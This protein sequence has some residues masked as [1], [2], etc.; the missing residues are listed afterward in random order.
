MVQRI[1]RAPPPRLTNPQ[2]II[3]LPF[4]CA[5]VLSPLAIWP[6]RVLP[7]FLSHQ[8]RLRL[9]LAFGNSLSRLSLWRRGWA[10]SPTSGSLV[11]SGGTGGDSGRSCA[12]A[13]L[14][15]VMPS[16]RDP[17]PD[18]SVATTPSG[19]PSS[20]QTSA[21]SSSSSLSSPS[22]AI[23]ASAIR[24]AFCRTAASILP[25][26]SGFSLRNCLAFSRP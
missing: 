26:T 3:V 19:G 25:A 14:V 17:A 21:A 13:S 20:F 7:L 16:S 22:P 12:G 5:S 23:I 11:G 1:T 10:T 18:G 15:K 24:P 6:S 8:R 4:L 2:A 9:D